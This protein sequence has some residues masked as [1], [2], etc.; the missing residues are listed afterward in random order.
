MHP[1]EWHFHCCC[2][3]TYFF[4]VSDTVRF[5]VASLAEPVIRRMAYIILPDME[6]ELDVKELELDKLELELEL[7]DNELVVDKLDFDKEE[8]CPAGSPEDI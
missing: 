3:A 6:L 4:F 1:Q 5:P 8:E 2:A 7:D